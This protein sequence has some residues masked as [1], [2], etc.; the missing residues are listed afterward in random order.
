MP[1]LLWTEELTY[2]QRAQRGFYIFGNAHNLC[3]A[4]DLWWDVVKIMANEP[5]RVGAK[6]PLECTN[7]GR[8]T[9]IGGM[10]V[11]STTL[12]NSS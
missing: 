6:F 4:D 8:K 11:L 12:D 5:R 7:H 1:G 2:R 10:I 3:L 9:W